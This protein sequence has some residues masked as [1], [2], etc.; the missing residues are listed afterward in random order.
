MENLGKID[1]S[2][3]SLESSPCPSYA[4]LKL[5]EGHANHPYRSQ[6]PLRP[7]AH[8]SISKKDVCK[9]VVGT[10]CANSSNAA[11]SQSGFTRSTVSSERIIFSIWAHKPPTFSIFCF[12][13]RARKANK[14]YRSGSK[15]LQ[16]AERPDA[17]N[18]FKKRGR[19]PVAEITWVLCDKSGRRCVCGATKKYSLS[20]A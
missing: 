19:I 14:T 4:N 8:R 6:A 18:V 15:M 1:E 5:F 11:L 7:R 10:N 13:F 20:T 16:K 12:S 17:V 3:T 2:H 9:S